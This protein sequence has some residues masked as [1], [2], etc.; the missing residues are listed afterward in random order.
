MKVGLM[1]P[2]FF[3]YIGQFQI[4][5]AVE[6]FIIVDELQYIKSGWMHRNRILNQ[7]T[8]WQYIMM[9]VG[10]H[11]LALNTLIRDVFISEGDQWKKKILSQLIV[12]KKIAPFYHDIYNLLAECFET[13]EKNLAR[14]NGF[15]FK[16]VCDYLEIPFKIEISSEMNFDYSTVID[17]EDRGIKM[18]QQL[19]ASELINPPGGV[20]LY[21]KENFSAHG[22]T[23]SFLKPNLREYNQRRPEFQPG[24]SIIDV[25][26][27]NSK[28]EIG[29][30]LNDYELL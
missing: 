16:K 9:P 22:L 5:N 30:M 21:S 29:K 20:E 3:P 11:R 28:E 7:N 19:G 25:M 10:K 6:R 15:F 24:L 17:K 12:Y 18:L 23:I 26:M 13:T 27:F 1:Q 4:I 2:Y 8:D 14:L